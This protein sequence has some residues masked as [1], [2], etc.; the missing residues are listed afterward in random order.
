MT[1]RSKQDTSRQF[2]REWIHRED[3]LDYVLTMVLLGHLQA[4]PLPKPQNFLQK[5]ST[6]VSL[7]PQHKS[8]VLLNVLAFID[9]ATGGKSL[10]NSS[11]F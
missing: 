11:M 10:S 2:G 9:G 7:T 5:L 4:C 1:V 3:N 8:I 6:V